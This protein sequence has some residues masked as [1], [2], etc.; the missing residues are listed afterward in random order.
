MHFKVQIES[1][2]IVV[3]SYRDIMSISISRSR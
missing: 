2:S 3:K 1:I